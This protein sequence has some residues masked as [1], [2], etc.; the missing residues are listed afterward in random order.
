MIKTHSFKLLD[1]EDL[2]IVVPHKLFT[3]AQNFKQPLYKI[4]YMQ[5]HHYY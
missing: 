4:K 3:G 2:I 5:K 1:V